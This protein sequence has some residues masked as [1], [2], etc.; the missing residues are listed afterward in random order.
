MFVFTDTQNDLFVFSHYLSWHLAG[1]SRSYWLCFPTRLG[2][3]SPSLSFCRS[4]NVWQIDA[5]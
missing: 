4:M 5:Y 3:L 2:G 1:M